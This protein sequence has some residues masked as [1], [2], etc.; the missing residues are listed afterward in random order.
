M[1]EQL[2][3]LSAVE[4]VDLANVEDAIETELAEGAADGIAK[5]VVVVVAALAL[6]FGLALTLSL[7]LA[8]ALA[9][10]VVAC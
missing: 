6:A 2:D 10:T 8:L 4:A 5:A 3:L 9:L 1:G 7:I